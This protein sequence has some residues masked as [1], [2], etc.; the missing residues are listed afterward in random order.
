MRKTFTLVVLLAIVVGAFNFTLTPVPVVAASSSV[1]AVMPAD[2]GLFAEMN[3]S[4]L[5]GTLD[6]FTGLLS[7]ANLPVSTAQLFQQLDQALSSALKRQASFEKD[8]LGWLGDSVGV[9]LPISS[10]ML[11]TTDSRAIA[12]RNLLVV[13]AVKNDTAAKAFFDEA[14]ANFQSMLTQKAIKIGSIDATLYTSDQ[15]S[16]SVLFWKGYLAAGTPDAITEL[17]DTLQNNKPTL[18]ADKNFQQVMGLLKPNNLL[19]AYAGPLL[20]QY[21]YHLAE[22]SLKNNSFFPNL[23]S[24]LD[25][26]KISIDGTKGVA[27]GLR[28]DSKILA[29]DLVQSIDPDS[30]KKAAALLGLPGVLPTKVL[31]AKLADHIPGNA[32]A[33]VIGNNLSGLYT[34]LRTGLPKLAQYFAKAFE[35]PPQNRYGGLGIS[36]LVAAIGT[37]SVFGVFEAALEETFNL[38]MNSEV[39]SWTGGEFGLYMAYNKNSE[40]AQVGYPFDHTF[41]VEA[42]DLDKANNFAAKVAKGLPQIDPRIAIANS[43]DNLYNMR[44]TNSRYGLGFGVAGNT[45]ILSTSSGLTPAVNAAKGDGVLSANPVWKNAMAV[46]PK[47]N[48]VVLYLNFN[49]IANTVKGMIPPGNVNRSTQSV[50]DVLNLFDSAVIVGGSSDDGT[51]IAT[52]ALLLK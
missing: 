2:M 16:A 20:F 47:N 27:I 12:P 6:L 52:A 46:A 26:E 3:T 9:G 25:L 31:T 30:Q 43:G 13:V 48:E 42:T 7:K 51:S 33:V 49:E 1:A 45:F 37:R 35:T 11:T 44:V 28:A 17:Q 5:K 34:Y 18:A 15:L 21:Q 8:V 19:T 41:V 4:D 22:L 40:F 36:P 38:D 32:L 29:I 23:K 10:D 50:L 39:L 14:T 24:L